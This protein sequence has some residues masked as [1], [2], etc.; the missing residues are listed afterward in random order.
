[1]DLYLG[2]VCYFDKRTP[3]YMRQDTNPPLVW[4]LFTL[5]QHQIMS[6]TPTKNGCLSSVGP[7][8]D[9]AKNH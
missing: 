3:S 4:E 7:W 1:M 5:L 9:Q 8:E 2:L 6:M